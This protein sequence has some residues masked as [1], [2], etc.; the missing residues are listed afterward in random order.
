MSGD[1]L[2]ITLRRSLIGEKHKPGLPSG[3]W[4]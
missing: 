1:M 3:A 4:V 2:R